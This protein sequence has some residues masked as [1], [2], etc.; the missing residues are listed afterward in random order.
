MSVES[1]K[2]Q[3][4]NAIILLETPIT[5]EPKTLLG[6]ITLVLQEALAEEIQILKEHRQMFYIVMYLYF[7]YFFIFIFVTCYYFKFNENTRLH[8]FTC[9]E[10]DNMKCGQIIL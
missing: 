8:R 7:K 9:F 5:H 3:E 6:E 10:L 2:T 1:S 4:G